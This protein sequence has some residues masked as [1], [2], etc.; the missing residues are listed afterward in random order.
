MYPFSPKLPSHPGCHIKLN[1]IPCA[2][3]RALLAI[4]FKCS[5][6]YMSIP[7]SLTI[8]SPYSS[9]PATISLSFMSLF[10]F[11]KFICIISF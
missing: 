4:H 5:S 9:Q 10:L 2:N 7:H 11:C 1:R 6:E 8:P 3:R